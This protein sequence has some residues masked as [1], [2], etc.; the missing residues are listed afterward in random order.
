MLSFGSTDLANRA[1]YKSGVFHEFP[2]DILERAESAEPTPL[3]L[4]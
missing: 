2:A 4:S 3:A 1:C